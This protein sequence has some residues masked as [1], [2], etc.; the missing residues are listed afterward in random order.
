MLMFLYWRWHP[1]VLKKNKMHFFGNALI[2]YL[3]CFFWEQIPQHISLKYTMIF[4]IKHK[5]IGL[6]WPWKWGCHSIQ[7]G[8][9][10]FPNLHPWGVTLLPLLPASPMEKPPRS[11]EPET[12]QRK[13]T[14]ATLVANYSKPVG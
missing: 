5:Q 8:S 12:S 10:P 9:M 3:S 2:I 4:K 14:Q 6:F 7:A 11:L 1:K 13:T